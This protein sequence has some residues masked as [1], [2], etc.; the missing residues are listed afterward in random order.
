[1]Y[2]S[3]PLRS[4]REAHY[5]STCLSSP[6]THTHTH[7]HHHHH[8]W[9]SH[10]FIRS[11]LIPLLPR[12]GDGDGCLRF[13]AECPLCCKEKASP[14]SVSQ[15]SD[16]PSMQGHESVCLR[17]PAPRR[18]KQN[19]ENAVRVDEELMAVCRCRRGAVPAKDSNLPERNGAQPGNVE[20]ILLRHS[21]S[22]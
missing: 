5:S 10:F 9:S 18:C 4:F 21:A 11:P 12:C 22:P 16:F 15:R 17:L 14:P 6:N 7:N 8:V 20:G 19:K 13:G 2:L 3:E 1:M